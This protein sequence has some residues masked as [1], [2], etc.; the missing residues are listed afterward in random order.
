MPHEEGFN[1]HPKGAHIYETVSRKGIR[2]SDTSKYFLLESHCRERPQTCA[3]AYT[4]KCCSWAFCSILRYTWGPL[5]VP[6]LRMKFH[7]S[8]EDLSTFLFYG[9]WLLLHKAYSMD[10]RGLGNSPNSV[11]F[12][13]QIVWD[14]YANHAQEQ[15]W[16]VYTLQGV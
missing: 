2:Y 9:E 1:M 12:H 11:T 8:Q 14:V 15:F 3:V 4:P 7:A 10:P 5:V 13:V 16:Y 6:G